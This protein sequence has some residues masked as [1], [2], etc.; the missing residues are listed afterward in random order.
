MERMAGERPDET[1]NELKRST[2][3]TATTAKKSHVNL[4]ALTRMRWLWTP[5][6]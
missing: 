5:T 1:K 6:D 3:T 4:E 2:E